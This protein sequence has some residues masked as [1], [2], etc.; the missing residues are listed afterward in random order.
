M[1]HNASRSITTRLGRAEAHVRKY[2]QAI[3]D[4]LA[5][6]GNTISL[7]GIQCAEIAIDNFS[8]NFSESCLSRQSDGRLAASPQSSGIFREIAL[9]CE[10]IGPADKPRMA[11][12]S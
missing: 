3:V 4:R 8:C 12:G 9:F 5:K 11:E 2:N 10:L 1:M 6:M 7:P